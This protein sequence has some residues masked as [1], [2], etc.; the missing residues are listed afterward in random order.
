MKNFYLLNSPSL[1][2]GVR[3]CLLFLALV[4]TTTLW[5]YDFQ[6]GNLYYELTSDSTAMVTS[7]SAS[8][9]YNV[10]VTITSAII[11]SSVSYSGK[12]FAVTAI[13]D[14]A[15]W[16]CTS[17]ASVT[18]PTSII[19][20]GFDAFYGTSLYNNSS[21]WENDVLYIGDCL[22]K[23]KP[24]LSGSYVIKSNT[25]LVAKS[26]FKECSSLT[27]ITIPENVQLIGRYCFHYCESLAKVVWNAKK[28]AEFYKSGS[29]GNYLFSNAPVTSFIFGEGVEH[30]PGSIC[31]GLELLTSIT[32][33]ANVTS[34]G[35]HAFD[36][37]YMLN[38]VVLGNNV[39]T[40]GSYAFDGCS[41]LTS[42][43]IP[44]SVT[45]IGRNAFYDCSSLTSIIWNAKNCANFSS[46][47]SSPFYA[48][49]SQ[50]TSFKFGNSVACVPDYL[51]SGMDKVQSISIPNSVTTIGN[52]AFYGCSS[53]AS[54]IIP[55]SVTSIGYSAFY[56]C[57]SLTSITWNAKNCA[58]FVS[59]SYSPFYAIRSQITSFKFGNSVACVPDYLCS[60]MDKVQSISIPNSVTIIGNDAFYGC[61]SLASVIISENV[62]TIGNY[63]FSGC[64]SLASV[65]IPENVT[66]IGKFAFDGCSSLA[67]VIIPEN[68]TTIGNSAF[69][70]CTSLSSITTHAENPSIIGNNAF[71]GVR[72]TI[73]VYVPCGSVVSYKAAEGW[74]NFTNIQEPLSEY[75]LIIDTQNAA[76]GSASVDKN[77]ACGAQISATA[78]EGYFF[79]QW[80][81]GNTDNPRALV[82]NRDTNLIAE[83]EKDNTTIDSTYCIYYTS[84]DGN[85]ITPK[86]LDAFGANLV[87]NIYQ[88]SIGVITFDGVVTSIGYYAFE[89]S[90]LASIII[91]NGVTNIGEGAFTNC[92]S[93]ISIKVEKDN[94]IYDSREDCNAIIQT[95]TNTL[96]AGCQN[97]IIPNGVMQI[98]NS[99]FEGCSSLT[100][101]IIPNGVTAI[102]SYAFQNCSS[103]ESIN[104]PNDIKNI[105]AS[106]FFGCSSLTSIV[107]PNS[108][109]RILESAFEGCSSL[110]SIEI[111]ES[112]T[113]IE[114]RAF[115]GCYSINTIY[116]Y[117]VAPPEILFLS[118]F[119][120]CKATVYVPCQTVDAYKAAY[121][122]RIFADNIQEPLP[123]YSIF[124]SAQNNEMGEAMVDR[125]TYCEGAQI[126]ATANEG[127]LFKQWSDGNTDNPRTLVLD[128]DTSLIAEFEVEQKSCLI[129]SGI[130]GLN[131]DNLTWQLS[132]DSILTIMGEGE[133]S[134]YSYGDYGINPPWTEY[135]PQ[136]KSIVVKEGV[137][138]I[139]TYAFYNY[140]T[141]K[142][143]SLKDITIPTSLT[144]TG[145]SVFSGITSMESVYITDLEVWMDITHASSAGNPLSVAHHLYVNGVE[146]TE[147]VVPDGVKTIKKY[148]FCGCE[149][150]K[151]LQLP[152]SIELIENDA[153]AGT[154]LIQ[155]VLP[156]GLE[157]VDNGAFYDCL[158]LEKLY[159]SSTVRRLGNNAF[160]GCDSLKGVYIT[161]LEAWCNLTMEYSS[162]LT[163]A[164]HL[165]LNDLE[166]TEVV[167]PENCSV[168]KN[169]TFEGCSYI[170]SIQLHDNITS[171]G[172]SAFRGCSSL[173]SLV[174]PASISYIG[175]CQFWDCTALKQINFLSST[176]PEISQG[177]VIFYRTNT[178]IIVPCGSKDKYISVINNPNVETYWIDS[179]RFVEEAASLYTYSVTTSNEE[180]G[181]IAYL[182]RPTY[183]DNLTLSFRADAND[184]YIFRQWS[185]GNTDN[186]RTLVLTQ[187]TVLTA[188]FAQFVY[189][190]IYEETCDSYSWNGQ[191]YTE[192]GEYTYRT[193][194]S[195]GC[196]SVVTLHLTINKSAVAEMEYAT[197]CNGETYTWNGAVYNQAGD[198]SVT[199]NT[200]AGCD[201]V[202]SLKLTVLPAMQ[203]EE[204]NLELCTSDLPYSWYG[205]TL[206]EA[207]TYT[208]IEQYAGYTCDS[209]E[210][211]LNLQ[212]HTLV[213]PSS[214][215]LPIAVCGHPMDVSAATAD[216]EAF[217]VSEPTY[218]AN[219]TVAWQQQQAGIWTALSTQPLDGDQ[220]EVIVRYMIISDC[221]VL[222]AP[223]M[224]VPVEM[225]TPEN[226]K[227]LDGVKSVSKYNNR[228]FLF[229]LNDFV[230]KY[231]WT[232]QPEQVIWYKVV[233]DMDAY[234]APSNDMVVGIGHS[235]NLPDGSVIKGDYYA[236]IIQDSPNSNGCTSVYRTVVLTATQDENNSPALVPNV[237]QP[238]AQL[239]LQNLDPTKVY[240][241]RVYDTSGDCIAT[242]MAEYVSEF[243][244]N[245]NHV[246]GYYLVDVINENNKI[247]LRY[248]VK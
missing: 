84:S 101:I 75:S 189:A 177:A 183:C 208:Y 176:P 91:P 81:D 36:G 123:A 22:I 107:I 12:T 103:L 132:C 155:L 203:T 127:Y 233:G 213:L 212:V 18:I 209:V 247:T 104:I 179:L 214:I 158:S 111:G 70:N 126:S 157:V 86:S 180:Q 170:K 68:V 215:S 226:S 135:A 90:S 98:A 187:D 246:A 182:Q 8:S 119:E 32:I 138:S 150:L 66:T 114:N 34:I 59:Q 156:E 7:K 30:I 207:G 218:A 88:D 184:G 236:L 95:A 3:G 161:D 197:I 244:F 164:H 72:K 193:T 23:A 188:I 55:N 202:V 40:I 14:Y 206:T 35:D 41:S 51:C 53:L 194:A 137:T 54:V 232:P 6:S 196:D 45:S 120:N 195:N 112:V 181:A 118:T 221:G 50:I 80:S 38:S 165:Y 58:N 64:S 201:S 67:S 33:P 9:P 159:I 223:E 83:F 17:L 28:C 169:Y 87:S 219:A 92:S 168:V 211:V 178:D 122:W 134:E 63:A 230:K 76:M 96:I 172:S 220:G 116:C 225:P 139:G 227:D 105:E 43:T 136:I 65:I 10:G 94:A 52:D 5:A 62:T 222:E 154:G 78:N 44:N 1:Q 237:V 85:I 216:I 27:A 99:A 20:I 162:P 74:K 11:P 204:Q 186:P 141:A 128:K 192:S 173:E 241:V 79:K 97:T 210:H 115:F 29:S 217:I 248:V 93:L 200:V 238:N 191:V 89:G 125:N 73:P 21:K 145:A 142:Y 117:P 113:T 47:T 144:K 198:Y 235:Y 108:V 130:C 71:Y 152:N 2:R 229:H 25:R 153:F 109:T 131:G 4:A 174:I 242:Y 24:T 46:S 151:S 57:S 185:D 13:D 146:L 124:V 231:G 243:L 100:N 16:N 205:Q 245:A 31:F 147:L 61:S 60:G 175:S 129:A 37:C 190:D 26:A 160:G 106:T 69:Y 240:E 148:V 39:T 42:V 199:L 19:E 167:F 15:F 140:S 133:M 149:G 224:V 234:G 121:G 102:G 143:C 56:G 239:S 171:I 48:I 77:T 110:F 163:D 228:I 49:R 166:L 82:L